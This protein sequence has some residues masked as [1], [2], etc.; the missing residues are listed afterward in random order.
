MLRV[1][2][3][4]D[5]LKFTGQIE[6]L[7]F[8][9]SQKL[10]I[11]VETE[12]FSDGKTL[13]NSIQN[14]EHYQLIFIDIEME[15]VDGI[16]A[17]RCIREIDRTVLLIYVSGCPASNYSSHLRQLYRRLNPTSPLYCIS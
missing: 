13:L 1:A 10:G 15:Q 8:Q 7:V 4:D 17:A 5:D 2:I 12:V 3:C 9:E 11:R 16:T 14:G 6:A